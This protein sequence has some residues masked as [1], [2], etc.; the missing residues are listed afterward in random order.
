M[1][2]IVERVRW[3]ASGQDDLQSQE[4]IACADEIERLRD[5]NEK[6]RA[7]IDQLRGVFFNGVYIAESKVA[8]LNLARAALVEKE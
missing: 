8:K 3:L 5:E 2:D 1:I 7:I 6:L 4:L